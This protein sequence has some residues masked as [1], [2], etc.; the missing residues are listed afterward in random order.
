MEELLI[1]LLGSNDKEESAAAV[2]FLNVY[3]DECN[4]Q[5]ATPYSCCVAKVGGKF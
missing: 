3:E 4:W 5:L 2:R 1:L